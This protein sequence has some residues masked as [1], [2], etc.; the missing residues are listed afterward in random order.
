MA[1]LFV[2]TETSGKFNFKQSYKYPMQPWACQVGMI[3]S[4][5]ETIDAEMA[6][7]IKAEGR[8]IEPQAFKI[9]GIS[10]EQCDRNGI[11]E[12]T[13][14]YIFLELLLNSDTLICHNVN[15]DR[16]I[17]A[18][19]LY[20]NGFENEAEFLMD[21]DSFCTMINGTNITKIP[22]KGFGGPYKWPTLQELHFNLFNEK[23]EGAHDAMVDIKATRRCYYKLINQT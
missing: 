10:E 9:H 17:V 15:F 2:D 3:L 6:F 21:H 18:H 14:C 7:L 13:A 1:E 19:M 23:I 20:N 16:V 5:Q 4:T 12:N 8:V 11:S 22:K